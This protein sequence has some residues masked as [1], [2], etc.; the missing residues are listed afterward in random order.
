VTAL[1]TRC[2]QLQTNYPQHRGT[3]PRHVAPADQPRVRDGVMRSTTWAPRDQ[4]GAGAGEASN[5][6]DTCGLNGFGQGHP[7]HD[8]REPPRQ[9]RLARPGWRY[10]QPACNRHGF[11]MVTAGRLEIFHGWRHSGV[12]PAMD[13]PLIARSCLNIRLAPAASPAPLQGVGLQVSSSSHQAWCRLTR[14]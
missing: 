14:T 9:H 11:T 4:G 3:R 1:V 8:G 13:S 10:G 7:R 12:P 2:G 5:T 6:M